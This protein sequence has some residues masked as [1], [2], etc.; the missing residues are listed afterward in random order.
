MS[1]AG[2]R[3]DGFTLMGAVFLLVIVSVL[4]AGMIQL[5]GASRG[6]ALLGVQGARAYYAAQSGIEWATG[7]LVAAPATCPAAAFA[8][9][10]GGI[11]GFSVTVT[12]ARTTHQENGIDYGVVRFTSLAERGVFGDDD[13]VSRRVE[14]VVTV[15]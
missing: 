15:E 1:L 13:Y 4:A 5:V 11:A 10:E 14:A 3:R 8:V 12:C 2:A 6:G 7:E 9:V